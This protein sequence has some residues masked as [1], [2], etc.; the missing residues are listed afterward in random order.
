MSKYT[1]F[2]YNAIMQAYKY[3]I[4]IVIIIIIIIIIIATTTISFTIVLVI[5]VYML[6]MTKKWTD[7]PRFSSKLRQASESTKA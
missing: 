5:N 3:I 4:I 1:W 2:V 6:Y 7:I